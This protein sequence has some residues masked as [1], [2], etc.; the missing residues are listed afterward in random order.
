MQMMEQN[1]KILQKGKKFVFDLNRKRFQPI[2]ELDDV[3]I[4]T[5]KNI[6]MGALISR[7]RPLINLLQRSAKKTKIIIVFA[8]FDHDLVLL[9]SLVIQLS[10]PSFP[11]S[12]YSYR[13]KQL[14]VVM[15]MSFLCIVQH[16]SFIIESILSYFFHYSFNPTGSIA[17]ALYAWI[18]EQLFVVNFS[19]HLF[20]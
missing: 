16:C 18:L 9:C 8:C 15:Q 14:K 11:F 20:P 13:S 10:S 1:L 3:Q 7:R 12:L 5:G 17:Y 6:D 4:Q 2:C 19:E